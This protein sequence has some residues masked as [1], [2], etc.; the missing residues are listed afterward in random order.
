MSRPPSISMK[1][2]SPQSGLIANRQSVG[3]VTPG[4]RFVNERFLVTSRIWLKVSNLTWKPGI[5]ETVL[6]S[7]VLVLTED[8]ETLKVPRGSELM[9]QWNGAG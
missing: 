2:I 9:S 3:S 5:V 8:G 4:S 1:A 7:E 6:E